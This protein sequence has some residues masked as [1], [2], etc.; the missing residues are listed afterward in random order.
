MENLFDDELFN[1]QDIGFVREKVEDNMA[2]LLGNEKCMQ[3]D[4]QLEEDRFKLISM[5][6][7]EGSEK[8]FQRYE[9]SLMVSIEHQNC[10]A[11]YI[12][13]QKGIEIGKIK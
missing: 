7:S 12:G 4:D 1:D 2:V 10:L 6:N 9:N 3:D 8:M 13:L 11:Y 5:L